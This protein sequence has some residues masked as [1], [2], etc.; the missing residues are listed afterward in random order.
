MAKRAKAELPSREGFQATLKLASQL[1]D[2]IEQ[3]ER[4]Q[5]VSNT[6]FND[7]NFLN[8]GA[9]QVNVN[10]IPAQV[11]TLQLQTQPPAL[12][13]QPTA[14]VMQQEANQGNFGGAPPYLQQPQQQ[15][16]IQGTPIEV[17]HGDDSVLDRVLNFQQM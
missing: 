2:Y 7:N 14:V 8:S 1:D 10:P 6:Q 3:Y 5:M 17:P 15:Q 13:R 4:K 12:Q 11:H 16:V 9:N